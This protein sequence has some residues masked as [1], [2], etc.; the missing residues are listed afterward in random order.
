M[1]GVAFPMTNSR[2]AFCFYVMFV[3]RTMN[4]EARVSM[5]PKAIAGNA[6]KMG[7]EMIA[8]RAFLRYTKAPRR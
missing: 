4:P 5:N 7:H 6:P 8:N 2:Y 1:L 3:S